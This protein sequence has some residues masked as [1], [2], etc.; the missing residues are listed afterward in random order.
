MI[1]DVVFVAH[2][3][4]IRIDLPY[5]DAQQLQ[6]LTQSIFDTISVCLCAEMLAHR[7]SGGTS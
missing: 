4:E 6:R 3:V 7:S 2:A 5:S 1:A